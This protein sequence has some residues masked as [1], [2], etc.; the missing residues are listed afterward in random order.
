MSTRFEV[1]VK[2]VG[3]A[4]NMDCT[5]C[6][7]L[8]KQT[9]LNQPRVPLMSFDLL[10]EHIRQTLD[11]QTG[12]DVVFHWQGGEPTMAGIDFFRGA[13]ALQQRHRRAGQ[14]I[15]N[16]LQTN[17]TLLDHEWIEFLAA[18]RFLVG[19]SL[20]G[21]R[22]I[23]DRH[24]RTKGDTSVFDRVLKAACELRRAKIPFS[25][26]C[27][28]NRDNACRPLEV[29]RFLSREVRPRII[30]FIPGYE[31][32]DFQVAPPGSADKA[33]AP[34]SGSPRARPGRP[35]SVVTGW[36]VDPDEWGR[37]L[38]A[39]WDEWLAHDYGRTFVDLFE[40]AV[41]ISMGHGAQRCVSAERCGHGL[42]L[43]ADGS[44]YSCDHYVY[45]EFRLGNIGQTHQASLAGSA[46]Q[47]AFGDAKA[48][49]LPRTCRECRFLA[50]C[51]GDCPKSRFLSA[52]DGEPGLS[53]LCAGNKAF[54]AHIASDLRAIAQRIA[55]Q[56]TITR[57]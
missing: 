55:R 10:E 26:L 14:R 23:N 36:S 54:F 13:V 16:N 18:H 22:E 49:S 48:D 53:Y 7:Y 2:P 56:R 38:C 37:F 21:P 32:S 15:G 57:V 33:M 8:H 29:Y 20:D 35:D 50:L 11:S 44:L 3:A 47:R 46:R 39:V 9:L 4:C 45:P 24:R 12:A 31:P 30:Q 27:V 43:E 6:Y 41:S 40:D 1:M 52:P 5:Y 42:A 19:L 34:K 28:V 51:G 17:G 25:A